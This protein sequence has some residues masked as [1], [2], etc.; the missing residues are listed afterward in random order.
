MKED[1]EIQESTSKAVEDSSDDEREEEVDLFKAKDAEG[2]EAPEDERHQEEGNLSLSMLEKRRLGIS[3]VPVVIFIT[4]KWLRH[5]N[6]SFGEEGFPPH[7]VSDGRSWHN[8]MKWAEEF[9]NFGT[10]LFKN[11]LL[12]TSPSP[13]D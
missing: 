4:E 6:R 7:D 2:N 5:L 11:C 8:R 10:D 12:Y 3:H 1:A 9:S 13:R